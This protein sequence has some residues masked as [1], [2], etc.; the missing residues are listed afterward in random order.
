MKANIP[1]SRKTTKLC[2]LSLYSSNYTLISLMF[3]RLSQPS[4]LTPLPLHIPISTPP[5]TPRISDWP[6]TPEL[7]PLLISRRIIPTGQH[8]SVSSHLASISVASRYVPSLTD[9]YT[10]PTI[11]TIKW[12]RNHVPEP[13]M[14][15][16][17]IIVPLHFK[18]YIAC[19]HTYTHTYI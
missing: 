8:T 3:K 12:I 10:T 7:L 14:L 6:P 13:R 4:S 17:E 18:I 15:A 19:I 9:A 11:T 16:C 5:H 1:V 2:V